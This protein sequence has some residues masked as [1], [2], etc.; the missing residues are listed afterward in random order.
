MEVELDNGEGKVR[1]GW[2]YLHKVCINGDYVEVLTGMHKGQSRWIQLSAFGLGSVRGT[3]F[4]HAFPSRTLLLLPTPPPPS[5]AS[6]AFRCIFRLP[7]CLPP[8]DASSAPRLV[9]RLQTCL[10]HPPPTVCLISRGISRLPRH[11]SSPAVQLVSRSSRF[12][13][14]PLPT[15]RGITRHHATSCNIM[16]HTV[17]SRN[18]RGTSHLPL[19]FRSRPSCPATSHGSRFCCSRPIPGISHDF[20]GSR[21]ESRSPL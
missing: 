13:S 10:L 5:D 20:P 2:L 6:S 18:P 8:P 1:V 11:D 17:M 3:P 4:R 16:Q 12:G 14:S 21:S 7:M 9:L 19:A 15:S